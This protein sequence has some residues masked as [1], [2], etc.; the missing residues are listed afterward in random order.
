MD[1]CPEWWNCSR[2]RIKEDD[3][4]DWDWKAQLNSCEAWYIQDWDTCIPTITPPDPDDDPGDNSSPELNCNCGYYSNGNECIA[5]DTW[6]YSVAWAT[7]CNSCTN[8]PDNSHYTSNACSNSCSWECDTNYEPDWSSCV[9]AGSRPSDEITGEDCDA[10]S[11]TYGSC[12]FSIWTLNHGDSTT[13]T[14]S[15]GTYYGSVTLKCLDGDWNTISESCDVVCDS[16]SNPWWCNWS[17]SP[18][19]YPWA[20]W[21]GSYSYTCKYWTLSY[22]CSANCPS[23]KYWMGAQCDNPNTI[24]WSTHNDCVN[25]SSLVSGSPSSETSWN[26]TTYT[27][28]CNRGD[29]TEKCTQTETTPVTPGESCPNWYWELW[30]SDSI[31]EIIGHECGQ[32]GTDWW[33]LQYNGTANGNSCVKCKAKSCPTWSS[34]TCG[35]SF[36]G[37]A[38]DTPCYKCS[39]NCGTSTYTCVSWVTPANKSHLGTQSYTWTCGSDSCSSPIV[40][41]EHTDMVNN[42]WCWGWRLTIW[43]TIEYPITTSISKTLWRNWYKETDDAERCDNPVHEQKQGSTKFTISAWSTTSN[44]EDFFSSLC[45]A[46][47]QC[48]TDEW[49]EFN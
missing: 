48:N 24:C 2:C 11:Y 28:K 1:E 36:A 40:L 41:T 21:W 23:W 19:G 9:P 20:T 12:T 35:G 38:W 16:S 32:S 13:K 31:E 44:D 6:K 43:Y 14:Y 47:G 45:Q 33:E 49:Y 46:Y 39:S 26:T 15:N 8:K 5:C 18:T 10:G 30:T 37:Y 17:F 27:W 42:N 22:S 34:T 3:C 25:S 4:T 29:Y 7:S